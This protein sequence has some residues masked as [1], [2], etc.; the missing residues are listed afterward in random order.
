MHH[1]KPLVTSHPSGTSGLPF[2]VEISVE[3][4]ISYPEQWIYLL[5]RPTVRAVPFNRP[6]GWWLTVGHSQH[7]MESYQKTEKIVT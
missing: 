1:A 5:R 3:E 4:D 6:D 7:K 2:R